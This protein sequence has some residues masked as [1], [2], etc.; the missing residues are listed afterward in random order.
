MTNRSGEAARS[1]CS[2]RVSS[3]RVPRAYRVKSD[4]RVPAHPSLA[5]S[6]YV[7]TSYTGQTSVSA[8]A[9]S[10]VRCSV[11]EDSIASCVILLYIR[12]RTHFAI[13]NLEKYAYTSLSYGE[14]FVL[15]C[16]FEQ[17]LINNTAD[18]CV[19]KHISDCWRDRIFKCLLLTY[20]VQI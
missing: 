12:R 10:R 17:I 7:A 8:R 5:R 1:N 4:R 9:C 3:C 6:A 13:N 16:F 19:N 15:V 2:Q 18:K 20:I 11:T 14:F